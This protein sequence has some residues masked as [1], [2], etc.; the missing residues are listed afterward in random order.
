MVNVLLMLPIELL[1]EVAE[2][3]RL[4]VLVAKLAVLLLIAVCKFV[5]LALLLKLTQ[6][7]TSVHELLILVT[8]VATLV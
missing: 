5:M 2:V 7:A 4:V 1:N 3:S 8:E 6:L